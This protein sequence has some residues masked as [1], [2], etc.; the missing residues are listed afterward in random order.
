MITVGDDS[1]R[2]PKVKNLAD[3]LGCVTWHEECAVHLESAKKERAASQ[4]DTAVRINPALPSK[5][6]EHVM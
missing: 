3:V 2:P 5:G 4:A 6:M 1:I